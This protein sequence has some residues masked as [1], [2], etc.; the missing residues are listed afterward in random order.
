MNRSM[1]GAAVAVTLAIG[2]TAGA[3]IIRP[4]IVVRPSAFATASV[5]LFQNE[6]MCNGDEDACWTFG[7]ATQYRGSFELALG[8]SGSYGFTATTAR[9]PMRWG[10]AAGSGGCVTCEGSV[11]ISQYLATF[12]MGGN[13][14]VQQLIDLSAGVTNFTR[15]QANDGTPLGTGKTITNLTFAVSL[16][17]GI[18]VTPRIQ[19]YLAQEYGVVMNK[20]SQSVTDNSAQQQ[21]LRL[22]GRYALGGR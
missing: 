6:R 14:G 11:T 13:A 2:A 19:V 22:G 21:T 17:L 3:Q 8:A 16:G 15:F 1:L 10:S 18:S 7:T 4:T 5:G 12:H 20:R 9:M